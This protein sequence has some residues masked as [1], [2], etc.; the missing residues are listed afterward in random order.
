MNPPRLSEML[1]R[2]LLVDRD[3]D[4]I[5]GDL[6]EE[7]REVAVPAMGDRRARW[8]YRRQVAGFI[9]RALRVPAVV[10]G[11]FGAALG[12]M[13]LVD[14]AREPLADD[15]AT[16][17]LAWV[18]LVLVLWSV[19]TVAVTWRT[20]RASDAIRV[21]AILGIAALAVFQLAAIVRVNVFL[22]TIQHRDD[23]RNLLSRYDQS[24]VHSLRT[25]AN[26][27][28]AVMMTPIL[29][30]VGA[31]AGSISG[32]MGAVIQMVRQALREG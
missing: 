13:N 19:A 16:T 17:I 30:A 4:T 25:Y 27:E 32:A 3:R 21:G 18:A 28:Y 26:Y 22:D 24:G 8:W 1:L 11:A 9:W 20:R 10:G 23:W 5:S 15:D 29:L 6:L 14:T 7:F 2:R 12:V 31:I